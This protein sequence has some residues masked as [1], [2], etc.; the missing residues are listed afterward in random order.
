MTTGV[1]SKT[2][3][4]TPAATYTLA[5]KLEDTWNG[6]SVATPGVESLTV[7]QQIIINSSTVGFLF[8]A[9][10]TYNI[11]NVCPPSGNI[12]T[13]CGAD[14]YYNRTT[15][16][17][18]PL[19]GDVIATGPNANSPFA[20]IGYYS[21]NCGQSSPANN[22]RFFQVVANGVVQRVDTCEFI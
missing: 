11:G 17:G 10:P 8:Q 1:L 21:Y 12:V 15:S 18:T 5:V 14:D 16:S 7:N 6:S 19:P 13:D 4:N 3:S 9:S 2:N 22:R 20:T